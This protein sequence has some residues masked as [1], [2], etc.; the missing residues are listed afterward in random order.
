MP[1]RRPL[2]FQVNT[3][4]MLDDD[5]DVVQLSLTAGLDEFEVLIVFKPGGRA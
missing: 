2:L 1:R 4:V 3:R 5:R